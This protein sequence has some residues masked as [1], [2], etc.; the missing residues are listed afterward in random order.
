METEDTIQTEQHTN[1]PEELTHTDKIVGVISEPSGLFS[2]LAFQKPKVTDWLLPLLTLMVIAIVASF[3]YMSNPEI[4]SEIMM[5]QQKAMQEQFDKMVES[6]QMTREQ[7]DEQIEKAKQMVDNPMFIYVFP[8]IGIIIITMIW[9]FVIATIGFVIAKFIL[10]GSGS[11]SQALTAMGLPM[12]ISVIQGIILIIIGLL[13]GKVISGINP[14]ALTGM[15]IKSLPGFLLSRID[16]FSIWIYTVIGIAFAKMFKSDNVKKYV[17]ASIG[18]WL[19]IM[20]IVFALGQVTPFF[21]NM[22]R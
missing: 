20:L 11:Y 7:A 12:Y 16:I 4:K 22:I 1:E 10:K 8:S 6:G 2:K 5:Q 13:M 21:K 3:I 19:V 14:A 15:D 17:I 18:A 9:F